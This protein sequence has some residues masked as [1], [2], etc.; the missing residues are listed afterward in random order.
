MAKSEYDNDNDNSQMYKR[1]PV[2]FQ[3]RQKFIDLNYYV[4]VK[5][6]QIIS[7]QLQKPHIYKVLAILKKQTPQNEQKF[8]KIVKV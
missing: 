5:L 6:N 2:I 8:L 7:S 1:K 4:V 3:K